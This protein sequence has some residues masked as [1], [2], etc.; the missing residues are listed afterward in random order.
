MIGSLLTILLNKNYNYL[1]LED[2]EN[3]FIFKYCSLNYIQ[4]LFKFFIIFLKTWHVFYQVNI[5]SFDNSILRESDFVF[6][7]KRIPM[8]RH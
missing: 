2:K 3:L 4:Q 6:S 8:S 5:D 7:K 1:T